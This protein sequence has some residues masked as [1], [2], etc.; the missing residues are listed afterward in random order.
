MTK[1]KIKI[2]I[3][4][5]FWR[6][7]WGNFWNS[8]TQKNLIRKAISSTSLYENLPCILSFSNFFLKYSLYD[9]TRKCLKRSRFKVQLIS[10]CVFGVYTFFEKNRT[11]TS[12][13]VVNSNLFVRF[14][15]ETLAWKNHFEFVWPLTKIVRDHKYQLTFLQ[16]PKVQ[17][18]RLASHQPRNLK[19]PTFPNWP[20]LVGHLAS[21]D[22][23]LNQSSWNYSILLV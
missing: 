1:S 5:Y 21:L 10:K 14:L 13:Q 23:H 3:I 19:G 17:R 20:W 11:K 16:S 6:L 4:W 15:E 7:S 2:R 12:R 9:V 8:R 18:L 22:V